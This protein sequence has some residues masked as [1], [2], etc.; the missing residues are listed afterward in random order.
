MKVNYD[1]SLSNERELFGGSLQGTLLGGINYNI[2][3]SDCDSSEDSCLDS[4]LFTRI[5][6]FGR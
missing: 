1:N 3:S 6:H 4:L 5:H 2:A